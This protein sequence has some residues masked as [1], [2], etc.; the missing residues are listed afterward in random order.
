MSQEVNER[1]AVSSTAEDAF[2]E[3][4]TQAFGLGRAAMLSPQLP[5]RDL[6]GGGRYIDFALRTPGERFAFEVDGI[7]WHAP[8]LTTPGKYEDDLLK[9]N[10]LVRLGWRVYRWTDRQITEEPEKVKEQLALFLEQASGFLPFEDFLPRQAGAVLELKPHQ[11]DAL[12]SLQS[13]RDEGKTIALLVHPTGSGK[14]V[15]A[16]S[17]AKRLGGR[18]LWVTHTRPLVD[19][20]HAEFLRLWP[21]EVGRYLGGTKEADA[22]NVV[23]TVQ[24]VSAGLEDFSPD[25]FTYLVIDEAHHGT[26]DTYQRILA[27]FRPEFILGLTATPGR[28]DG[29]PL[30]DVFR[31][32][33]HRLSLQE[34]V[35]RGEL[36][37][38]RCVRVETNIDLRHVRFNQVN[39]NRKDIEERIAVPARDRL[40]VETYREYVPGRRAVAFAVNVRHADDLA[41]AFREGGFQAASV[42]GRM[43]DGERDRT[44]RTFADGGLQVLCACDLL[45]EGWD[46]PAVEVLLMARPTLSRVIYL[47]QLGRGTRKAPGKE[48]LV[49][50]DFVDAASRYNASLSCH[51]VLGNNK[52]RKGGLV[53]GPEDQRRAEEEALARGERPTTVLDIGLWAADYQEIDVFNWQE[54][55]KDMLSLPAL[56]RELGASEGR[57]RSAV[58]REVVKPDHSLAMGDH[59][60]HYIHRDRAE[61]V[62]ETLGL[63]KLED[64]T[65]R[66]RF[67]QFVDEMDMFHS[68]KPVMLLALLD[69]ADD[70]GKAKTADVA[71]R[72]HEFY[73]ARMAED[74]VVERPGSRMCRPDRLDDAD[75]R[76]LM[77]DMPFKKFG[78]RKFLTHGRDRADIRFEPALWRQLR[79]E[80]LAR[81]RT[82]CAEAIRE[83]YAGL[84]ATGSGE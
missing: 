25:D 84:E 48:C 33:A 20:A 64:S 78:Q 54:A 46:C 49:V 63:P 55:N 74:K 24:S 14:T 2:I 82:L 42:S 45:N 73:R 9:Q 21:A 72:F 19:Q 11:A 40:I 69:A 35:E 29:Q 50:F 18:T 57:I 65:V 51:R 47:Q 60:I 26:A 38:I 37:P 58:E 67:M 39:Y 68:Y 15:T 41:T 34:A 30:L 7:V 76:R 66:E 53:L 10:S 56:E 77:L 32:Q 79:P 28:A 83:Y 12:A 43:P 27:H 81:V 1:A 75:V 62:R 6:L 4:F 36:A 70:D 61:E 44:L 52:Y 3:L 17:D 8:E 71:R 23:G 31:D 16:I 5:F 80:D 59:L 13:L 22:F